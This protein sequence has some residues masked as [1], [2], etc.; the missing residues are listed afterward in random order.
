M[1]LQSLLLLTLI[2]IVSLSLLI[3]TFYSIDQYTKLIEEEIEEELSHVASTTIDKISRI[4]H[5]RFIDVTFLTSNSNFII[6][7]SKFTLDEKLDY[8]R[9]F[10]SKN[11][12]YTSISLYD[13]NGI[14]IGDTRNIRIGSDESTKPFFVNAIKGDIYYD[15]IPVYSE[16]LRI[17]VI[18]FASP[19]LDGDGNINGV[20]VTRFALSKINDV[21]RE[22]VVYKKP[23]EI[24]LL[25]ENGLLIFSNH[26]KNVVLK[27]FFE[28]PELLKELAQPGIYDVHISY[29][30]E[31]HPK[32]TEYFITKERGYANYPGSNWFIAFEVHDEILYSEIEALNKNFL[33]IAGLILLIA[34]TASFLIARKISSPITNL[35]IATRKVSRGDLNTKIIPAGENEIKSLADDFNKMTQGLRDTETKKEE[36]MSM[37]SHELKTPLVPIGLYSE[38]LLKSDKMGSL[39][40]KQRK[41]IETI[42]KSMKTLQSLVDDV[43]DVNKLDLHKLTLKKHDVDLKN[44][45]DELKE[46]LIP[47]TLDKRIS[48]KIEIDGSWKIF[49]DANRLS[50]IISNL[51]KNSVDFVPKNG[52]ITLVVE[53]INNNETLFTVNDNGPGI[54]DEEKLKLFGKFY[55]IDSS[56]TRK[57]GGSGLGLSICRGLVEAHGGKIWYDDKYTDGAS[58]KFNIPGK[59]T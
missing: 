34:I 24:D 5:Q 10:E 38:M 39:N 48:F 59:T 11:K 7:G 45:L 4:M 29:S 47:F 18:H 17:P 20:L 54:T 49:I 14:K 27:E 28:R 40:D 57:H 16:S 51:V 15:R 19:T 23:L 46:K 42:H 50:Q 8:L 55:Q 41:A 6:T 53:K 22:D 13:I 36:F 25:A 2:P 12:F 26:R 35:A 44:Y 21:I 52:K 58:F 32:Q 1:K 56:A 3:T 37:I 43:L 30:D 33:I 9:D 31:D